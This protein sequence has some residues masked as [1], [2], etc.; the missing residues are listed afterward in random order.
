MSIVT[1]SL[2]K[3]HMNIDGTADDELI[4]LYI[5]AAETFLGNYIGKPLADLDPLPDDLKLAVL[6]LVAFYYEQRE[7]VAFGIT[8]QIAPYGVTSIADSYRE[9]W[10]GD[11]GE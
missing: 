9:Y 1:L 6:K 2:A 3:A 5:G 10:F 11:D 7:A 8:M 4:T